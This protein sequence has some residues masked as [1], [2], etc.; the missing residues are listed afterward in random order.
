MYRIDFYF[1]GNPF[2]PM[3]LPKL[4]AV[5]VRFVE[6]EAV[7]LG[8]AQPGIASPSTQTSLPAS[9]FKRTV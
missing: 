4:G 8:F 6:N 2:L 9:F 1:L 3:E 5:G 7:H